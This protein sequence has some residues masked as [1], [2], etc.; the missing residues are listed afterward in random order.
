[1]PKKSKTFIRRFEGLIKEE[2]YE[3]ITDF[4]NKWIT[5]GGTFLT[6]YQWL[7][8]KGFE[9]E[10]PTVYSNLRPYLTVPY[11]MSSSFWNKWNSIAQTKGFENIDKMMEI[12]K[13]KY[14]NTEMANELGVTTRTI[15]YLK[16]RMDGDRNLSMRELVKE[17]RPSHKDEDGFTKTDVKEKWN[18]ILT[19]KGFKSLREAASYYMEKKM[20]PEAMAKELGVTERALRIRMEKAGILISKENYAV[21]NTED[22]LGLL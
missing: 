6:I 9:M 12:Y 14:T 20:S 10:P 8:L 5:K 22:T 4:V 21:K 7:L 18:K 19:E 16:I 13:K 15:E 17:K 11:D 1:M 3:G 2:G